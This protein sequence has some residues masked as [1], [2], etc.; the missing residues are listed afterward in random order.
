M[1]PLSEQYLIRFIKQ[2]HQQEKHLLMEVSLYP[3]LTGGTFQPST[4]ITASITP[5]GSANRQQEKHP[6]TEVSLYCSICFAKKLAAVF[7]AL[8]STSLIIASFEK[9]TTAPIGSPFATIGPIV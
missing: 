7:T 3:G 1:V 2:N 4:G 5:I 6:L 8:C 9:M